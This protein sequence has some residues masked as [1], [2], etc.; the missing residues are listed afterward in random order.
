[1]SGCRPG[2]CL[3]SN[4]FKGSEIEY[5]LHMATAAISLSVT[6]ALE[7]ITN[8]INNHHF[9]Y[10]QMINSYNQQVLTNSLKQKLN[11]ILILISRWLVFPPKNIKLRS[12][13]IQWEAKIL[14]LAHN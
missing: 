5:S 1:M 6:E 3:Q 8:T 11:K 4:Y 12:L 14:F 2:P 13:L 9:N 10:H 7:N